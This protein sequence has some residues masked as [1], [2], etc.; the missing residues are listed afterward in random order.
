MNIRQQ[1]GILRSR[2]MYYWKPNNKRRLMKFY[3]QFVQSG[4]LCFDIGAHLGNRTNAWLHL[5]AKVVSVEP[6]PAC[7]AYLK[8]H[9][10]HNP[11]M[12]L[13][14]KAVGNEPGKLP[15]FVSELTP[16]ITT[17]AG[18][19]WRDTMAEKTSFHV[20]WDREVE[21]EVTTLDE[22][23]AEFGLPVFCKIDVEDFELEVLK[24]LSQALPSLS[25]EYFSPTMDRALACIDRLDELGVYQYNW[26]FGESQ[27]LESE[28]WLSG[29][30]IKATL[31]AYST[32]DPS[33]DVY[34]RL[35]QIPA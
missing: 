25:F 7:I 35:V 11:H 3:S 27:R 5:G 6:Q 4:D 2:I 10:S 8:R 15:L 30:E 26:S 28:A 18:E 33:G 21:V 13:L 1:L 24:G 29:S 23:I 31:G 19:E 17:L 12:T 22:L 34:A 32:E 20:Q 9:L 16:T 14:E